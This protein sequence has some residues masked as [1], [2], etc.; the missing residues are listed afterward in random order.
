MSTPWPTFGGETP[1]ECDR[2]GFT[3][4]LADLR[5]QYRFE[6]QRQVNTGFLVC[7]ECLDEPVRDDS[8]HK[9][10]DPRPVKHPRP[11]KVQ[12]LDE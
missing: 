12:F 9:H 2:C 4:R 6:G 1:G 3:Y 10:D 7:R 5:W 11:P 8:D